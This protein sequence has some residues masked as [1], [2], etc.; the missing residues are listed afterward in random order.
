MLLL[1][2]LYK[3]HVSISFLQRFN[4]TKISKSLLVKKLLAISLGY[5][6]VYITGFV[7]FRSNL[8]GATYPL[9]VK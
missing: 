5:L 9:I 1:A 4:S 7:P 2:R 6:H 3:H 8:I